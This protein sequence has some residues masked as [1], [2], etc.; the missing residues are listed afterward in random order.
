MKKSILFLMISIAISANSINIQSDNFNKDL[1]ILAA[2]NMDTTNTIEGL[3]LNSNGIRDDVESYINEKYKNDPF[4][5]KLFLEASKTIQKILTL[6]KD[7]SIDKRVALDNRLINIY[8]CRDYMLYKLD[9]KDIEKE[10]EEKIIFKSKVLNTNKRLRAYIDHKK[11]LPLYEE[12]IKSKNVDDER[13]S[14]ER[15]YQKIT[16]PDIASSK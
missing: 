12:N 15:L 3:D 13:I 6:P 5:Q 14:C 4:Q 8:T 1:K 10:L 7:S 2:L 11:A 16:N 9:V